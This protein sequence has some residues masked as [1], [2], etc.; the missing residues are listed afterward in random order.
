[1]SQAQDAP[2]S[3][4][5]AFAL[6]RQ[7]SGYI[8]HEIKPVGADG[9]Y[10]QPEQRPQLLGPFLVPADNPQPLASHPRQPIGSK[11][12]TGGG[13]ALPARVDVPGAAAPRQRNWVYLESA[14]QD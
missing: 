3:H 14:E 4:S 6:A 11:K 8:A 13:V 12:R 5:R 9:R 10:A 2:I 1:M 7:F